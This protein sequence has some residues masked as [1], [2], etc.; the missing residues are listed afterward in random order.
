MKKADRNVRCFSQYKNSYGK[1]VH[2]FSWIIWFYKGEVLFH[3]QLRLLKWP[4]LN[5]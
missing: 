4:D 1:V 3:T 2:V 5:L